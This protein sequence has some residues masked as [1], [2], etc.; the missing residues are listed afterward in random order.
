M[1]VPSSSPRPDTPP[2]DMA[3][4]SNDPD[5]LLRAIHELASGLASLQQVHT[6]SERNYEQQISALLDRVG[7]LEAKVAVLE[8][9]SDPQT[10]PAVRPIDRR[11]PLPA[12]SPAPPPA[13]SPLA[14]RFDQYSPMYGG[15]MNH[16]PH[17][18]VYRGLVYPT[19]AHLFEAFKFID[20]H[21]PIAEH[22]RVCPDL[23]ALHAV[24]NQNSTFVRPNW[25]YVHIEV[26]RCFF[27]SKLCV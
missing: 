5:A 1:I 24:A 3:E 7:Q 19:A 4:S 20:I 11:S 23:H 18:V 14:V 2:L 27:F 25:A 21:P 9:E 10:A 26:V 22:I 16:S 8:H 13:G 15:F 6:E 17:S 12:G